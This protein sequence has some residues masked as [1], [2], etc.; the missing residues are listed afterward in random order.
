MNKLR[1]YLILSL[2]LISRLVNSQT[3]N[4][5]Y[6]TF[7]NISDSD[8]NKLHLSIENCNFLKNNE[9]FNNFSD[10]Y[11]L[12]GYYLKPELEYYPGTKSRITAGIHLL[13]YSG[14]NKYSQ[15]IPTFSFTHQFSNSYTIIFGTLKGTLNHKLVE[16]V[17]K[18]ERYFE[19]NVEN[20]LQFLINTKYFDADIWSDWN[21]FIF[22]GETSQEEFVFG[23][24][25]QLKLT[26]AESEI[27][28]SIPIQFIGKHKGG[29]INISDEKVQTLL[30]SITG[31]C[32]TY[33]TNNNL[34]RSVALKNYII[35]YNDLSPD[36]VLIFKSG[37]GFSSN[38]IINTSIFNLNLGYWK[39]NNF[40]SPLGDPIFQSVSEKYSD[41]SESERKIFTGKIIFQKN[42]GQFVNLGLRFESYY[43]LINSNF[44]YSFGINIL[45][46][47]L[48]SLKKF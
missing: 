43:D 39:A 26:Q 14:I 29:Q 35:F 5:L 27:E 13:K 8:Y 10:G 47:Q 34:L 25:S 36:K 22:K 7:K 11:T 6:Y 12:I 46:K 40:I 20:G 4:S 3:D 16:P 45:F 24:S 17:Y 44:D 48:V 42:I 33:H 23:L 41:F 19:N 21:K 38:I 28:V 31:L 2:L 18:F 15:Y 32:L 37:Q 9:Y 1:L 30:N